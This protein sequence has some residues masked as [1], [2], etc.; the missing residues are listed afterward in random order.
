MVRTKKW[1]VIALAALAL[2]VAPSAWAQTQPTVTPEVAAAQQKVLDAVNLFL[3]G[4][5]AAAALRALAPLAA[6]QPDNYGAQVWLGYLELTAGDA[7]RAVAPLERAAALKPDDE[8]ALTNLGSALVRTKDW[9][10]GAEVFAALDAKNPGRAMV[11]ANLGHCR[12]MAGDVPGSVDPLSKALAVADTPEMRRSILANLASA[13]ARTGNNTAAATAYKELVE[14][15]PENAMALSWLGFEAIQRGDFAEAITHLEKS[16]SVNPADMEAQNNLAYAYGMVRP[17]RTADA[18]RVY[19]KMA[20]LDPTL[21]EPWYNL[22]SLY[23]QANDPA[24]AVVANQEALK[25]RPD[26]AYALNNLGRAYEAQG[27]MEMAATNYQKAADGRMDVAAFSRNAGLALL[28]LRRDAEAQKYLENAIAKGDGDPQLRMV[29]AEIYARQ[30]RIEDATKLLEANGQALGEA[31]AYWFNL[32][33]LKE[34]QKDDAGA[35]TAYRKALE[36]DP[37]DIDSTQNLGLLLL[38]KGD[39]Q[40][41][42]T[43][44]DRLVGLAPSSVD[45]KINLAAALAGTGQTAKAVEIWR[46][47]VRATPERTDIRLDLANG[48]WAT[49]D[50]E[51]ARFHY[52]EALRRQPGSAEA[53]NGLGLWALRQ[54]QNKEAENYF[55][56]AIAADPNLAMAYNN[57]A[58]ALERLNRRKEAVGYLEK[59]VALQP[60]FP[61]ARKNLERM[62][63]AGS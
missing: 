1:I 12:L 58:A 62:R 60:D 52:A 29:L 63:K 50:H 5:D 15:E 27:R 56:R 49:G 17:A 55:R 11:L 9:K 38:R 19:R 4:K 59:A 39:A 47:I 7:A 10:R 13:H 54:S 22:G 61:E 21:Y 24:A 28:R 46:Q 6:E 26:E 36:I 40:G 41:A 44:F 33:V 45:A 23:L 57:L 30:G 8:I 43:L 51:G 25:R 42:L 14:L 53:L 16:V 35:E 18:V 2:S 37:Q 34:R 20:E 31:A 32:G 3:D 48:L